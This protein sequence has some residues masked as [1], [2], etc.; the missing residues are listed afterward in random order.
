MKYLFILALALSGCA[1][2]PSEY[3]Q[4]C[5]D[6][7]TTFVEGLTKAPLTRD[8]V[9]EDIRQGCDTLDRARSEKQSVR[10]TDLPRG[11]SER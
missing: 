11:R 5:Q 7:V 2:T 4:G 6:G 10:P 1:T 9:K 8:D 3:S